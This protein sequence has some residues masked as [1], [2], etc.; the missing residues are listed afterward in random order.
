MYLYST[1]MK[2]C[3]LRFWVVVYHRFESNAKILNSKVFYSIHLHP[4]VS[5]YILLS[6]GFVYVYDATAFYWA[7][8]SIIITLF[9]LFIAHTLVFLT[10]YVCTRGFF[11][12]FFKKSC[13]KCSFDENTIFF[14]VFVTIL[15]IDVFFFSLFCSFHCRFVINIFEKENTLLGGSLEF[16][17]GLL[18]EW[19]KENL[20]VFL[21]L[22]EKHKVMLI[23]ALFTFNC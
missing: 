9:V 17:Q 14:L 12:E 20:E 2:Y 5:L 11:I 16:V 4:F 1:C 10:K 18:F 23:V 6:F 8:A 3:T 22:I 15:V 13:F 7:Q 21:F 19:L